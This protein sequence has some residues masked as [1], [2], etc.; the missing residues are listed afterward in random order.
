MGRSVRRILIY[1]DTNAFV[2]AFEGAEDDPISEALVQLFGAEPPD[3]A[4]VFLTSEVALCEILVK[5]LKK[6]EASL[7]EHYDAL[8]KSSEWL[9]VEPVSR[10]VL[11]SAASLRA[12]T[13]LKLPDAIHVSTAVQ[14]GCTHFLTAD[15]G[16]SGPYGP[17]ESETKLEVVRLDVSALSALERLAVR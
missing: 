8:M 5:P 14:Y 2:R 13:G 9:H 12:R 3:G 1:L 11:I 16:I 17:E 15:E 4:P 7:V 10:D 6:G